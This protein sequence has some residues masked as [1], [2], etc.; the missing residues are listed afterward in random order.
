MPTVLIREAEG[1]YIDRSEGVNVKTE[2]E[3]GVVWAQV[4]EC[5]QPPEAE[6]VKEEIVP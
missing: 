6:R 1:N 2:A 3:I 5:P 4:K